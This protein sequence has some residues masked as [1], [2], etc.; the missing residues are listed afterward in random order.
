M[1]GTVMIHGSDG[2][3]LAPIG[4]GTL[5]EGKRSNVRIIACGDEDL[6]LSVR[7]GLVGLTITTIFSSEQ[8]KGVVPPGSRVAYVS[9]VSEALRDANK[10]TTAR[11]LDVAAKLK[12]DGSEYQFL[13][14][15]AEE[16]EFVD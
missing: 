4:G 2:M 7:V 10:P 12:N 14:F 9:E 15:K 3:V 8:L 13:V 16:Y 6:S 11:E 1:V 5:L